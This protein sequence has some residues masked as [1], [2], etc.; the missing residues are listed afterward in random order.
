[1]L[2]AQLAGN[3][4]AAILNGRTLTIMD[5]GRARTSAGT[6]VIV[7]DS[8]PRQIP[9]NGKIVTEILP[10]QTLQ[11][12]QLLKDL[13]SLIPAGDTVAAN[14]AGK[15]IVMTAPQKDIHRISEI[16][17]ALDSSSVSDVQVFALKFADSKSVAAELKEIFHSADSE[18]VG[19]ASRNTFRG[20]GGMGGFGPGP[21]PGGD[22][23]GNAD[24]E[25]NSQSR[26]VFVSDDQM[27]AVVASAPPNEMPLITNLINSLD[28]QVQDITQMKVFKLKH[29]DPLEIAE[30]LSTLFTSSNSS[31]DENSR[32][33]GFEF[34]P[35]SQSGSGDSGQSARMKRK[36][37]MQAV[38]DRRTESVVVTASKDLMV[39]IASM[40]ASLDEGNQGMT[41]VT[42]IPLESADPAS[43]E[44]TMSGL[45]ANQGSASSSQTTTALSAR[46][47]ADN[48]TQSS[49][50]TS[51][52]SGFGSSSTGTSSSH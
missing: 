1:L 9:V 12:A 26:V 13:A 17:A 16:I 7:N 34:N 8:G 31:S 27:N 28:V 43:V 20:P 24:S 40:I 38:A 18:T 23:G 33:T 22:P 49:S 5:A 21:G 3:N 19:A 30:E 2:N 42:A 51:S 11:A 45:F 41:H 48:N 14:E 6:P 52:T 4:F 39:A 47:Q 44:Q 25:K 35:F 29:A 32:S 46:T 50:S 36:S 37:A 10:L 15:A